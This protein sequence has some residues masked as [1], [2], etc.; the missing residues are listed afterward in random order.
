[1]RVTVIHNSAAGTGKAVPERLCDAFAAVGYEARFHAAGDPGW[2]EALASDTDLIAVAGGDGTVV[3]VIKA[4]RRRDVPVAVLPAGTANNIA[5]SLGIS[6]RPEQAIRG[7]R[8]AR[9]RWIDLGVV[10]APW[11]EGILAEGLGLG[12]VAHAMA[13]TDDMDLDASDEIVHARGQLHGALLGARPRRF[14]VSVDGAALPTEDALFVEVLNFPLVG[15][16]LALAPGADP[17]DGFF[18]VVWLEAARRDE[19]LAWL[20]SGAIDR[21][22]APVRVARGRAVTIAWRGEMMRVEDGFRDP[23]DG[24]GTI[25]LRVHARALRM[26]V[27]E[28]PGQPQGA[29][30][31]PNG[32]D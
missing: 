14:D 27:Q 13:E 16:R 7:W 31:G 26:L 12:C 29:Q 32:R 8:D 22:P 15:P 5:R 17:G 4:M 18:D 25:E 20:C 24:R 21:T 10:S 19:F 23:E 28:P 3:K 9:P 2:I 6:G 30:E 1:M 11:G